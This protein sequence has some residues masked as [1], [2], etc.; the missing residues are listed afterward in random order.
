LEIPDR[1]ELNDFPR[2]ILY[3]N[4][5]QLG[6]G[7]NVLLVLYEPDFSTFETDG[8]KKQLLYRNAH[9]GDSQVR[10]IKQAAGYYSGVRTIK[11]VDKDFSNGNTWKDFFLYL[12]LPGVWKDEAGVEMLGGEI[13][14]IFPPPLKKE[15]PLE[16][17]KPEATPK[18]K[19]ER[20]LESDRIKVE[21]YRIKAKQDP[22]LY[23]PELAKNLSNLGLSLG[24][25]CQKEEAIKATLEAV[26]ISRCLNEDPPM[27]RP[28][29]LGVILNNLGNR[30]YEQGKIKEA[31]ESTREAERIFREL[32]SK[33]GEN[34]KADLARSLNEIGKYL[35]EIG[36]HQE[37]LKRSQ[38]AVELSRQLVNKNPEMNLVLL[39]ESLHNLGLGLRDGGQLKEALEKT[40]EAADLFRGLVK[41]KPEFLPDLSQSLDHIG[42]WSLELGQYDEA[43]QNVHEAV[44]LRTGL[45]AENPQKYLADFGSSLDH[46]EAILKKKRE[47]T[48]VRPSREG[49][50][51]LDFD[52]IWEDA[53]LNGIKN[54]AEW[55]DLNLKKALYQKM[56]DEFKGNEIG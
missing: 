52:D 25:V 41:E 53:I 6:R 14:D 55:M 45:A 54:G 3:A 16:I 43:Y 32:T 40:K 34:T 46:L 49:G 27:N 56:R 19:K 47:K 22:G 29:L 37:G 18:A 42:M 26:E 12:S 20:I 31:L 21:E 23:L 17:S 24:E 50:V 8:G 39:A 30:L 35:S 33:Y 2:N 15:K 5:V 28:I 51:D 48:R 1:P 11:G 36:E 44:E 13:L 9:G 38:E 4:T 7:G 10:V